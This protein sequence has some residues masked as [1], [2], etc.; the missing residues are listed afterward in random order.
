MITTNIECFENA[1]ISALA[2]KN[3]EDGVYVIR[4]NK[5]S[6]NTITTETVKL[7]KIEIENVISMLTKIIN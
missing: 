2:L 4:L 1:E 3:V 7:S 6:E 5:F